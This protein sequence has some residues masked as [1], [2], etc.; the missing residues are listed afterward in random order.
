MKKRV[1]RPEKCIRNWKREF[2]PR[3]YLNEY[4]L[5]VFPEDLAVMHWV[6]NELIDARDEA[7]LVEMGGGP[8]IYQLVTAAPLVREIHF[9]DYLDANLD[10]VKQWIEGNMERSFNW[11]QHIRAGLELEG[12]QNVTEELVEERAALIRRKIR[13]LTHCDI[14]KKNPL[15]KNKKGYYDILSMHYVP[16]SV[17]GSLRS[18][19]R[20]LR[21]ACTVLKPDGKLIMTCLV[22]ACY[23]K[24]G[25]KYFCATPVNQSIIEE[26]LH[27]IGFSKI[28]LR[29]IKTGYREPEGYNSILLV[30]ACRAT[31]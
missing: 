17:T 6:R 5:S 24:V 31:G 12:F 28:K 19:E 26:V 1:A 3:D 9:S 8:T 15:G 25:A 22:G 27:E 18:W 7:V 21:N 23:F 13:Q 10:E 29:P 14:R 30:S 16:E 20:N 2:N 11:D 4:Y